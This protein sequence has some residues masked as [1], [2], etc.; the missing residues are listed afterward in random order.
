MI[1]VYGLS[2]ARESET[3]YKSTRNRNN[4]GMMNA[5]LC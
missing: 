3:P 2:S 1:E 5:A 4:S